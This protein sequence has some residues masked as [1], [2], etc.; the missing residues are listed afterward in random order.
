MGNRVPRRASVLIAATLLLAS[1]YSTLG[2]AAAAEQPASDV[3]E[4]VVEVKLNPDRASIEANL[5]SRALRAVEPL[6]LEVVSRAELRSPSETS[7]ESGAPVFVRSSQSAPSNQSTSDFRVA[8]QSA[9]ASSAIP[10]TRT[11]VTDLMSF[12][13]RTHGKLFILEADVP[14]FVCSATA[15]SSVER[16]L[17]WTAGHCV[18]EGGAEGQPFE[19]FVFIPGY[20]DGEE[21]HGAWFAEVAYTTPEWV[22][23]ADFRYD[24]AALVMEPNETVELVDVVGAR[25]IRFNQNPVKTFR[26]HG[27]PAAPPFDGERMFR[28]VS[29]L[30]GVLG[31]GLLAPMGIGCDMTEGSSGGGWIVGSG[32]AGFVQ[33]VNSFKIKNDPQFEDVMFGPQMR[34]AALEVYETAGGEDTTPPRVTKLSDGPDPF[35][36]TAKRKRKTTIRFTHDETAKVLFKITNRSGATVYRIP[37]TELLPDSY[38]TVWSGRNFKNNKVVKAGR[39]KY[40]LTVTDASGNSSSRSGRVRVK[41]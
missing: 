1:L 23:D 28:C 40:T 7:A 3:T 17:V 27:Y 29:K 39:Y 25:G 38:K 14:T 22:D 9:N 34:D 31:G 41:R 11:E 13:N 36:P 21:P 16:N 37:A 15:V 33:S 8:R 26:S 10:F 2:S 24:V 18:H 35:T 32:D 5:T 20:R 19:D 6:D 12:P 30:G 4:G